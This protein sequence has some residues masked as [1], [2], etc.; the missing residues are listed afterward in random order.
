MERNL[1]TVELI[2][3]LSTRAVD[4][5]VGQLFD[6]V[7]APS[8]RFEVDC[9]LVRYESTYPWGETAAVT[10]QFFLPRVPA[11][12]AIQAAYVFAPGT[13]GILDACRPSREHIAG[14][15]WGLY[16]AHVLAFAGQG[17]AGVLPDYM[18]FGDSERLQPIYNA[19]AEGRM[20]LD[21]VRALYQFLARRQKEE[22]GRIS[23]LTRKPDV[24]VAGFSQGGQP[25]SPRRIS[26]A[27]TLP[28]SG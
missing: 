10:A 25:P 21:A 12:S 4:R 14:I 15:R 23:V 20:M 3:T 28:M 11:G 8:S 2:E 27:G 22:P 17:I 9:Y 1:L 19:V 7:A 26:A 13:T 18:G 16:R 5:E 24:F 6:D